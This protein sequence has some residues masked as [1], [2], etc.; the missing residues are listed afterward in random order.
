MKRAFCIVLCVF[1]TL[2]I[3]ACNLNGA[4]QGNGAQGGNENN[5]GSGHPDDG[6]YIWRDGSE[7]FVIGS[8]E[9]FAE[10]AFVDGYN[11]AVSRIYTAIGLNTS[12]A[13]QLSSDSSPAYER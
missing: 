4:S 7:L 11:L 12:A 5:G 8:A 10:E 6:E 3:S 9:E 1:I 13:V 2:A